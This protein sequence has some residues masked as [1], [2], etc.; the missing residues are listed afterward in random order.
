MK[1]TIAVICAGLFF[2]NSQAQLVNIESKRMQTDST[3]FVLK[4]DL[5]FNY[6][7]NNGEYVMQIGS[8]LA[9]QY[10]SKDFQKNYFMILNYNLIRTNEMD[11]QN[12]WFFHTRYNQKLSPI[13]S[14]EAFIQNQNNTQLTITQRNLIGTGVRL[15]LISKATTSIYFG[16]SYMYEAEEI[17]AT[18]QQFYN[19][20]NSS[21]LSINQSVQKINLDIIATLYFQPLYTDIA[22]HRILGQLKTEIP[23]TDV[24]SLSA[25]YNYSRTSF[26]SDL[27]DDEASNLSI[28]VTLNI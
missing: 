25:L 18:D 6:T 21:Y 16:N 7:D 12:S 2:L 24:I 13:W 15:K 11:F 9:T 4:S 8:N 27:Q 1:L 10:K 17:D 26:S 19:H 3:R 20:R 28:G 23:L 5:L 22:N 14:L